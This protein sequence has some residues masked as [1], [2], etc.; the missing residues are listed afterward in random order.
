M[1]NN[2]KED[3][4]K[5]TTVKI[6]KTEIFEDLAEV[7]TFSNSACET[8]SLDGFQIDFDVTVTNQENKTKDFHITFQSEDRNNGLQAYNGY[9]MSTAAKY[10]CDDD[11]SPEMEEFLD[12]DDSVIEHLG[13][14]AEEKSKNYLD[15]HS[16]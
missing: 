13:A 12:Y 14:I 6:I 15:F 16:V 9:D 8:E 1:I 10:G 2:N 4:M 11:D 3:K 5:N 7:K